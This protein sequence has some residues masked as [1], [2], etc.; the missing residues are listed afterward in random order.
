LLFFGFN[1]KKFIH[2]FANDKAIGVKTKL[3]VDP[4]IVPLEQNVGRPSLKVVLGVKLFHKGV[5]L[6]EIFTLCDL[7]NFDVIFKKHIFGCL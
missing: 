7:D 4:I 6:F 2:D 1:N 5:Q 3:V